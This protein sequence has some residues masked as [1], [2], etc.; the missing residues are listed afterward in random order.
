V[1]VQKAFKYRFFPSDAQAAQLG[2][3]FGCARFVY[4]QALNYR[5]QA[6]R[7]DK[8]HTN[9]NDTALKLTQW[10]REPDKA[11]L[12]EV[13]SVVLQQSLRNLDTAFSNFFQKRAQYPKFKSRRHRQSVRYATNAFT[14]RD[15]RI[16]L[17]KQSEP[18]DIVW[19]QPLP[20]DAKM[21]NL[22]ISRDTSDRYFVS[23]LVE[24][25]IKPLEK[26]KAEVGI[27]VGIKTLATTSEGEKIEN[28]RPLVKCEKRLRI[29]QRRLSRKVKDSNNRKKARLR[30]ARLHARISDT[31]RDT[32]QKFTT[33]MI[34]E[35]QAIFVEG[36][37]VVGMV[38]NHNLA[39]HIADAAFGEIFQELE[40]KAAW[41]GR[42]YLPLERFFPSSKLCS[43]CGHLLDELPLAVREWDCPACGVHH[44]RDINAAI[45]IKKA[46]QYL[47][48]WIK[49]TGWGARKVTPTRN[50]RRR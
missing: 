47:L 9:Y 13:S 40:Y 43:S 20:S 8:K 34:G 2:R 10:K 7:Q 30:V 36:L 35:N 22:T 5:S 41:Y 33:K 28:P 48:K 23:I 17:A 15:G 4:N 32:L 46:G 27:D 42:T 18:L 6:W 39:K 38:K 44:D 19:S 11:F 12:S 29:L 3:T 45:N 24:T 25:N 16:I 37:N 49:T 21:L 26:A 50:Q 1:I 31:R 14:F